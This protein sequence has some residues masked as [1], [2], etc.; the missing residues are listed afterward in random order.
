MYLTRSLSVSGGVLQMVAF[1]AYLTLEPLDGFLELVG[2]AR[3][4]DAE[5]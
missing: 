1:P 4:L 2:W 3:F 5:L